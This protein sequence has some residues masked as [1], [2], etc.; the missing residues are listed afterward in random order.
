MG[1]TEWADGDLKKKDCDSYYLILCNVTLCSLPILT[2]RV[3]LLPFPWGNESSEMIPFGQANKQTL[4][5]LNQ[6][7]PNQ[8][9]SFSQDVWFGPFPLKHVFP[10]NTFLMKF[11]FSGIF[12]TAFYLSLSIHLPYTG[13]FSSAGRGG[14]GGRKHV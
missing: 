5:F 2:P 11:L 10:K 7:K 8:I 1:G 14:R 6:T 4:F 13:Q 12:E 3:F 9:S